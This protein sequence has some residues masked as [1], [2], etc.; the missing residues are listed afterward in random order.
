MQVSRV[1]ALNRAVFGFPENNVDRGQ[2][3]HVKSQLPKEVQELW[4]GAS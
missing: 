1:E 4:P 2:V 3:S